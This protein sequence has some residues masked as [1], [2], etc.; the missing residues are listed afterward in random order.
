ML[1]KSVSQPAQ[2]F[3]CHLSVFVCGDASV[4]NLCEEIWQEREREKERKEKINKQNDRAR[5]K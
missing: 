2:F 5:C 3:Q 4:N 1:I